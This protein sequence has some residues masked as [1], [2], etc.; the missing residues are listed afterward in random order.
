MVEVSKEHGGKAYVDICR[1]QRRPRLLLVR[2]RPVFKC[3]AVREKNTQHD[4]GQ[5]SVVASKQSPDQS[6]PLGFYSRES[7]ARLRVDWL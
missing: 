7:G 3:R 5:S 6:P 1:A 2:A 4:C